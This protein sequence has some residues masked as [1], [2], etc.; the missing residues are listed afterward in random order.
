[1]AC[2]PVQGVHSK[3]FQ[4]SYP[5]VVTQGETTGNGSQVQVPITVQFQG[6]FPFPASIAYSLGLSGITSGYRDGMY[7]QDF[8][9]DLT[10]LP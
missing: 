1:M 7:S 5:F 8:T 3:R 2:G 4:T 6:P 10:V 9:L